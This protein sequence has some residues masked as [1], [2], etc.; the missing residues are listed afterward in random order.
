[1]IHRMSCVW[2]SRSG[3]WSLPSCSRRPRPRL[4]RAKASRRSR[5]RTLT[6]PPRSSSPPD[7]YAAAGECDRA[8]R[9]RVLPRHRHA[10]AVCGLGHQD[11]G[12]LPDPLQWN[13]KFQAV[14]NGGWAGVISYGARCVDRARLRIGQHRYRTRRQHASF[15]VGHPEKITDM[16]HRAVH[17]M[18]VQAK[19]IIHAYYGDQPTLAFFNGCSFGGRQAVTAAQ[20]YPTDFDAVIAGAPAVNWIN[21]HVGRT[22]LNL[23]ANKTPIPLAGQ[24]YPLIHQAGA[25]GVRFA[26]MDFPRRRARESDRVPVRSKG[27]AVQGRGHCV[28]PDVRTGGVGARDV[29]RREGPENGCGNYARSRAGHR[30]ELERA[31]RSPARTATRSRARNT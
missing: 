30:V 16:A 6:L 2:R 31:G 27:A 13:S 7:C 28:V 25:A 15:A 4:C 12:R 1:M 23:A 20:R 9:S 22:A 24:K 8:R 26:S 10:D 17:E 11:R 29:S 3:W 5:C 21:L 18:T 19:A 14:G